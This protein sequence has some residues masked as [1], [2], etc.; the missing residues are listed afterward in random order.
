MANVKING[1]E[2]VKGLMHTSD[3]DRTSLYLSR[4]VYE[5][6][7]KKCDPVSPSQVLEELMIAFNKTAHKKR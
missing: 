6:F 4:S 2:I 5:E 7:K 3:R 1:K